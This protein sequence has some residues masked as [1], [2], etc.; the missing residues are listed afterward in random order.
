MKKQKNNPL[1]NDPLD[2]Y[3]EAAV[4]LSMALDA[5]KTLSG[6]HVQL[7]SEAER[8]TGKRAEI[9]EESITGNPEESVEK[10]SKLNAYK[11]VFE[12]KLTHLKGS[13]EKAELELQ[14]TLTSEFGQAFGLLYRHLRGHRI[15]AAKK[16]ISDAIHPSRL[17]TVTTLID[18][19]A[20]QA[21]AV[22]E[23]EAIEP[24]I[25]YG[26][27]TPLHDVNDI[28]HSQYHDQT[29]ANIMSCAEG[30]LAKVEPLLKAV[31]SEKG[32]T[33]PALVSSTPEP[34]AVQAIEPEPALA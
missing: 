4:E 34:V 26:C 31:E 19:L 32:F 30:V 27:S 20:Y 13:V 14:S 29:L 17:H 21:E 12:A 1:E 22:V 33:P 10:L 2:Q 8:V 9:L 24:V 6:K 25:A 18:R 23:L 15:E 5:V 16:R 28:P 7:R 3:R 11:E